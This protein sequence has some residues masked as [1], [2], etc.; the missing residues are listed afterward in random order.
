MSLIPILHEL[1]PNATVD[2][3]LYKSNVDQTSTGTI[4]CI[5][6]NEDPDEINVALVSNGNVLTD[7]CYV[8]YK[9][10]AF[11]GQSIYLQQIYIGSEDSI[12]VNSKNGSTTFT[13]TGYQY[14]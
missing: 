11:Y 14:P 12:I 9:T 10:L 13:F 4:F 2:S 1:N 5:N 6:R 8:C 7:N 3:T